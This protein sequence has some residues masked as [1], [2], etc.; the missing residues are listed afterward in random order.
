M[1]VGARERHGDVAEHEVSVG[2]TAEAAPGQRSVRERLEQ[3]AG[4]LARGQGGGHGVGV[5]R[6][7]LAAGEVAAIGLAGQ[8]G[9]AGAGGGAYRERAPADGLTGEGAQQAGLPGDLGPRVDGPGVLEGRLGFGQGGVGRGDLLPGVRV[10]EEEQRRGVAA[11]AGGRG[12]AEVAE[13]A[14]F[15]VGIEVGEELVEL[16]LADRVVFVVVAAAAVE[17]QRHPGRA[18]GLQAVDDRFDEPLLDDATALAVEAVVAV[19]ARGDDLGFQ[20]VRQQVAGELFDG[21]LVERL[22]LVV[23]ADDPVAPG[24][25]RARRVALEA[26]AVRVA[27][28]VEPLH[29]HL[30]A[31]VGRGE[32][33]VQRA[34]PR[35]RRVVRE[36]GLLVV[37]G[38]G[39]ARQVEG[40]PAQQGRPVGLG[41]GS[42]AFLRQRAPEPAVDG[43]APGGDRRDGGFARF[44]ESP[45]ALVFGALGD[46][47]A[48]RVHLGGRQH[49]M[50]FRRR[51]VVVRV[52]RQQP[53]HHRTLLR[54]A[55]DDGGIAGLAAL[56]RRLEGVEAQLALVLALVG[57]VAGEAGVGEDRPDVPVELDAFGGGGERAEETGGGQAEAGKAHG[58]CGVG[59]V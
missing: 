21:E 41:V 34:G 39:Q 38:R 4:E 10:R 51:H 57:A 48:D 16:L 32:E 30:L 15:L 49:L 42:E 6:G 5:V 46:P 7:I 35:V 1:T 22:V 50:E 44:L 29:R 59:Q 23:G 26:V 25:H 8:R 13:H 47:A 24:P 12:A 19:E 53:L 45:V 52:R 31:E 56:A 37:L 3:Q 18:G 17:R 11:L 28:E 55:G 58:A 54:L 43:V 33:P 36:E 2:V 20:R 27:G 40:G 14:R 9:A